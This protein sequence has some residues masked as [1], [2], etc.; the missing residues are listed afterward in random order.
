ML[1]DWVNI[2]AIFQFIVAHKWW[3]AALV[4]FMI[5]VAVLK[6]RG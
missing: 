4:P 1:I 5:A 6:A 2:D 3:L